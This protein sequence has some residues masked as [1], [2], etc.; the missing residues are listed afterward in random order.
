MSQALGDQ[1]WEEI[2]LSK[3]GE[4]IETMK[5]LA[6]NHKAK[7]LPSNDTHWPQ[8]K[9][10]KAQIV[11]PVTFR[12]VTVIFTEAEWKR[13]SPEES[14][15]RSDAGELQESSL[16]GHQ[17]THSE[18]KPYVCSECGSGFSEKSSSDT[19]GHTGEKPCVC[20]ECGRGFCDKSTLRK[21]QR[22]HSGEK[23]YVCEE[24]GRGFCDKSTFMIHK[25]THS[26]EKPYVCGECGRGF[27]W[28]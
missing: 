15:Q 12:D 25:R 19:R 2:F 20:L 7:G 11:V 23:P 14:I 9:E 13:L 6:Q 10:G 22:I 16:T 8:E 27:S 26:G 17:W 4:N 24:C 28:K 1:D 5:K 3:N 21:H 18:E